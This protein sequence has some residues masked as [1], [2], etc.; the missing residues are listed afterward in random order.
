MADAYKFDPG[1][2][3]FHLVMEWAQRIRNDT[4]LEFDWGK[5]NPQH[6]NGSS[7]PPMYDLSK[8]KGTHLA[9]WDGDKDLFV[10]SKD[11]SSLVAEVPKENWIKHTTMHNYAHFDFVWGKDAHTRLYPDIIKVLSSEAPGVQST[12]VV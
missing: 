8:I 4:L 2:S 1:C 11:M 3:S 10:T 6:Y 12:V 5:N 7:T 9:L